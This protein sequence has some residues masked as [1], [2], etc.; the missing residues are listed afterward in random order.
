MMV[1]Y[2]CALAILE[3]VGQVGMKAVSSMMFHT[4]SQF[5][6]PIF[7]I[8]GTLL[9]LDGLLII[10]WLARVY[11]RFHTDDCLP[12]EY[13]L[14]TIISVSSGLVF[15]QEYKSIPQLNLAVMVCMMAIGKPHSI[16]CISFSLCVSNLYILFTT[17][18]S[19]LWDLACDCQ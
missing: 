6:Q 13:G 17:T 3:S 2:P 9:G 8:S 5:S 15:F 12:V 18:P 4:E 7:W 10:L 16:I 11:K 14:V 1:I 19:N